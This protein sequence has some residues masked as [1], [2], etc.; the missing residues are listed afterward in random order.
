MRPSNDIHFGLAQ[1]IEE[2][3]RN[4]SIVFHPFTNH[5]QNAEILTPGAR[6]WKTTPKNHAK[7]TQPHLVSEG[8]ISAMHDT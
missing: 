4:S 6:M 7:Q 1:G 3:T 5:R 2:T 8:V